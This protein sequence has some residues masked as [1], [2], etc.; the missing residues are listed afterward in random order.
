MFKKL[1]LVILS[2]CA[3]FGSWGM[4]EKKEVSGMRGMHKKPTVYYLEF[5]DERIEIPEIGIKL[6]RVLR[7]ILHKEELVVAVKE[8][9]TDT[10]R[11]VI[12]VIDSFLAGVEKFITTD[13]EIREALTL[14]AGL[15]RG[16]PIKLLSDHQVLLLV[17]IA[18]KLVITKSIDEQFL[19]SQDVLEFLIGE[20]TFRLSK[21]KNEQLLGFLKKNGLL[22]EIDNAVSEGV[23]SL[24]VSSLSNW[25]GY[26]LKIK[27]EEPLSLFFLTANKYYQLLF[28]EENN[29]LKLIDPSY[30]KDSLIIKGLREIITA[31]D[32]LP[33]GT[34]LM[35]AK[36][37]AYSLVFDKKEHK[38]HRTRLPKLPSTISVIKCLS[39]GRILAGTDEG[40]VFIMDSEKG[41]NV[42]SFKD[43][44]L[45]GISAVVE[46][47]NGNIAVGSEQGEVV[48]FRSSDSHNSVRKWRVDTDVIVSI[49]ELLDKRLLVSAGSRL[50]YLDMRHDTPEA[51]DL[52]VD[53]PLARL[54]DG[55][56]ALLQRLAHKF[57]VIL[58]A[59]PG[60]VVGSFPL[61]VNLEHLVDTVDFV[62]MQDGRLVLAMPETE[63]FTICDVSHP[64]LGQF[65][66]AN[67]IGLLGPS[68]KTPETS[69]NIFS[70]LFKTKK[71]KA[72]SQEEQ[73][74]AENIFEHSWL[75]DQAAS[76][77]DG[78]LKNLV[79]MKGERFIRLTVEFLFDELTDSMRDKDYIKTNKGT[80]EKKLDRISHLMMLIQIPEKDELMQY[81]RKVAAQVSTGE[82]FVMGDDVK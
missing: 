18:D 74:Y 37:R 16:E 11:R 31:G 58:Y 2:L 36:K 39:D 56:L 62:V 53:G 54:Q 4:G 34:V 17:N 42:I 32:V 23:K 78:M 13:K 64:T 50:F 5:K 26:Q 48:I 8:N 45:G 55:R 70:F 69:K 68:I 25:D 3:T 73:W 75:L 14:Y 20:L 30:Q 22:W 38:W 33:N 40:F 9:E 66:I 79:T 52:M 72:L 65:V 6:S 19:P 44:L 57:T 28:L 46:L 47:G 27:L 24:V 80:L 43:K 15:I 51:T 60:S 1:L 59:L 35:L 10:E 71:K 77:S 76:L 12:L 63:I 67:V 29:S 49:V 21:N 7:D 81:Y 82:P 41:E 61:V